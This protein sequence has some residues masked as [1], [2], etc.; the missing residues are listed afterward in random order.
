MRTNP[1][2]ARRCDTCFA[3]PCD[4]RPPVHCLAMR[5]LTLRCSHFIAAS[6]LRS[7]ARQC[8]SLHAQGHPPLP[9]R[10]Y[11]RQCEPQPC[12]ALQDDALLSGPA[13]AMRCD[14]MLSY[15]LLGFPCLALHC[16]PLSA[17]THQSYAQ[18]CLPFLPLHSTARSILS[19]QDVPHLPLLFGAKHGDDACDSATCESNFDFSS[20]FP[21]RREFADPFGSLNPT[22]D[23]TPL[24][25]HGFTA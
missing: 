9:L 22:F 6:A 7:L 18:R 1:T 5:C 23:L 4:P 15:P 20:R 14:V 25:Q 11:P 24:A 21:E 16:D 3:L 13:M 17:H 2:F 10:C 19:L 8:A 12:I